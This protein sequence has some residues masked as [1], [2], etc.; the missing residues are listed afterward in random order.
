TGEEVGVGPVEGGGRAPTSVVF[1][2]VLAAARAGS[3]Q[4][5]GV[6][7]E[8]FRPYLLTIA[9]RGLPAHLRGKC[10]GAD[11]VQETLLEAHRGFAGLAGEAG[12][13]LRVGLRGIL[14]HNLLDLIRRY[15][16]ASK[17]SVG[18]ER[19]LDAGLASGEFSVGAVDPYPT[20]NSASVARESLR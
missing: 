9:Q 12:D 8:A 6:L 3:L 7:L 16:D 15:C 19:S 5:L 11:V 14:K 17:R 1:I 18:R 4:A 13:G 2:K 20:P 10:D